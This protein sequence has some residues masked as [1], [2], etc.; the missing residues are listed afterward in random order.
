MTVVLT[1]KSITKG[2]LNS[3]IVDETVV[4]VLVV[5]G[6]ICAVCQPAFYLVDRSPL[7]LHSRSLSFDLLS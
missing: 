3:A 1:S 7:H 6:G 4:A 2:D 5:D